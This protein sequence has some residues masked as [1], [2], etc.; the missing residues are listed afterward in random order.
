[1]RSVGDETRVLDKWDRT[2]V[3]V[4]GDLHQL[5]LNSMPNEFRSDSLR[6][7]YGAADCEHTADVL[8]KVKSRCVLNRSHNNG[9]SLSRVDKLRNFLQPADGILL[10][11]VDFQWSR[12]KLVEF[13]P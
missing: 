12:R 5:I 13:I 10:R 2:A 11:A 3:T 6:S 7:A 8:S 4:D 1:M 9:G